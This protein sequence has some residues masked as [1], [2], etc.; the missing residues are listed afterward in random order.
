[1]A[2]L[3]SS[4]DSNG[5]EL[6]QFMG[7][8][9]EHF[10]FCSGALLLF[11]LAPALF[12]RIGTPTA[13]YISRIQGE[14]SLSLHRRGRMPVVRR[15]DDLEAY[16]ETFD[17]S[18]CFNFRLPWR[19]K[20]VGFSTS[21]SGTVRLF[22]VQSFVGPALAMSCSLQEPRAFFTKLRDVMSATKHGLAATTA[23]Y[24][25]DWDRESFCSD[26]LSEP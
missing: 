7:T 17:R 1:M 6:N 10:A 8:K 13:L 5:S 21:K 25:A 24:V 15:L 14:W 4:A 26:V 20:R 12:L 18:K 22:F 3:T 19:V 16:L 23:E 2:A 11:L 9:I